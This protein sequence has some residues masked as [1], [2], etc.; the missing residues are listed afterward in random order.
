MSLIQT[1]DIVKSNLNKNGVTFVIGFLGIGGIA[2]LWYQRN[3]II[4][5]ENF[6]LR[7][8]LSFL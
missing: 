6:V 8:E 4:D 3:V 5:K 2:V 7:V 1:I